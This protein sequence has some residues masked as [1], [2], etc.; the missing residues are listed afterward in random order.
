VIQCVTR[1]ITA[2]RGL[3]VFT[4]GEAT[5]TAGAYHSFSRNHSNLLRNVF[6]FVASV[7]S[8]K[9]TTKPTLSF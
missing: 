5:G 8:R 2:W 3:S 6:A 7:L 4:C 1:T 9:F